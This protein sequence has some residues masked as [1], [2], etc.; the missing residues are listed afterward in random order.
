MDDA[1]LWRQPLTYPSQSGGQPPRTARR[2]L[3]QVGAQSRDLAFRLLGVFAPC[4]SLASCFCPLAERQRN[5]RGHPLDV[6]RRV[7]HASRDDVDV[8]GRRCIAAAAILVEK[9]K[10]Y[11]RRRVQFGLFLHVRCGRSFAM[12][13]QLLRGFLSLAQLCR[14]QR[15]IEKRRTA[16]QRRSQVAVDVLMPQRQS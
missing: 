2:E 13:L 15:P 4:V 11:A 6:V 14:R 16:R 3:R 8:H 12:P 5:L 1:A 9:S 7:N 10:E